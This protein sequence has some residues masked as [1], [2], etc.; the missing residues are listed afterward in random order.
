VRLDQLVK[1]I[2]YGDL[3]GDA[4][5]SHLITPT[6]PGT[7][8]LLRG[9]K[10]G[11]D[12]LYVRFPLK[13]ST[14]YIKLVPGTLNYNLATYASVNSPSIYLTNVG[15]EA[16]TLVDDILSIV[17]ISTMPALPTYPA[18]EV[19]TV[20]PFNKGNDPLSINTVDP[21][22]LKVP[23]VYADA[24]L[25]LRIDYRA[26]APELPRLSNLVAGADL[27][28]YWIEIG[29]QFQ[30]ALVA[31]A[32]YKIYSG[33]DVTD[34]ASVSRR[35]ITRYEV[36]CL[37]IENASSFLDQTQTEERIQLKGWV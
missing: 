29:Y 30:E 1:G 26:L 12:A 15:P 20:V 10:A 18:E 5:A 8:A 34:Q 4:W 27:S 28:S 6:N 13:Y 37:R 22:V 24:S 3:A 14:R 36:E 21:L 35:A 33:L 16:I 7:D 31:Y 32:V 19:L 2:L 25:V 9:I 11:M 17:S 23:S